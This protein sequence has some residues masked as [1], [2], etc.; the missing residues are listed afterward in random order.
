[1]KRRDDPASVASKLTAA[2]ALVGISRRHLEL[3]V[4]MS[5]FWLEQAG[6]NRPFSVAAIAA[7]RRALAPVPT[8]P[9]MTPRR[10]GRP[11]KE[12]T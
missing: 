9:D 8:G 1:M 11:A 7:G 12:R 3:L 5:E 2:D 6:G 10:R 4:R